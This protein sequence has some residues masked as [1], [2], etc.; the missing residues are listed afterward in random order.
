MKT[1]LITS[2]GG[3]GSRSLV[4]T[5]QMFDK[6]GEYKIIGTHAIPLEL[7]KSDLENLYLVPKVADRDAYIKA[8]LDLIE[9]FNVDLI[10]CN[11]DKEVAAMAPYL[12]KLSCAHLIPDPKIVD[13]V[14]DKFALHAILK[15]HGCNIIPNI[16]IGTRAGI[17]DAVAKL[18]KAEKFWMRQKGGSGSLGATW[19]KTAEQAEKWADL[20]HELRGLKYEDFV[21]S[22]FLPGRDFCVS[23]IFQDGDFCIGKGYERLS[24]LVG[25]ITLSGMG[26]TPS[27]GKTVDNNEPIDIS[28]KAVRAVCD[29]FKVRPHG[30]YQLDLKCDEDGKP[31]V[32]EINIGRFPMTNP[33]F[34]RVGKHVLLEQY[35]KMALDK[36]YKLPRDTYDLDPGVYILRSVDFPIVFAREEKVQGLPKA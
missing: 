7:V 26:S 20:W 1:I 4:E 27:N 31:Y 22:P 19:L 21:L 17:K 32:T 5:I 24:Y 3:T 36:S 16:E 15:K 28:I 12:D 35:I 25:D 13:T 34:D 9:K 14:Q 29:E 11:S 23:V 30:L 18:P 33:H 8:H 2:M 10:I 6:N